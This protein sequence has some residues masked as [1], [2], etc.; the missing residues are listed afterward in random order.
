MTFSKKI[1]ELLNFPRLIHSLC[2]TLELFIR[3]GVI[4]SFVPCPIF[5]GQGAL[6]ITNAEEALNR[7][8]VLKGAY[9][10]ASMMPF[11]FDLRNVPK[12]E[13]LES[14]GPMREFPT[15]TTARPVAIPFA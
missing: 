15:D 13:R 12:V 5:I 8:L 1:G 14:V 3:L 6:D 11:A 9:Q 2:L 4:A 7:P 10:C